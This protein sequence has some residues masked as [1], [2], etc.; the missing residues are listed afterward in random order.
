MDD[1]S[2]KVSLRKKGWTDPETGEYYPGGNPNEISRN[3]DNQ[4]TANT[5]GSFANYQSS[6]FPEFDSVQGNSANEIFPN[7]NDP[8]NSNRQNSKLNTPRQD[9][10]DTPNTEQDPDL[11]IHVE[12][13]DGKKFCKFCGKRIPMDAV[14]CTYCGRQVELLKTEPEKTVVV[15]RMTVRSKPR[16]RRVSLLLCIILGAVG[17]HGIHRFYEG[18]FKTGLL[19]LL[20]G[21]LF[22][23]GWI[24]DMVKILS[25]NKTHYYIDKKGK[26]RELNK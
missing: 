17:I 4:N 1:E 5:Q 21:G 11:S 15:N 3:T 16:N 10:D 9:K 23:I 7:Q 26:R 25:L 18:K 22:L 20:T 12:Y 8:Q 2:K 14:I 13:N 24:T 6:A 19:W